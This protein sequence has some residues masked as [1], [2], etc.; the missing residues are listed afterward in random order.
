MN[1]F[2]R[3][4]R[5]EEETVALGEALG[6]LLRPGDALALR[7]ELGAGKTRFV[8]GVATG[9][10]HDPDAV[11]SPTFVLVNEYESRGAA[12]LV[13]VDAYRLRSAADLDAIGWDRL[14]DGSC[15]VAVEWSERIA[16]AL[17]D[18]RLDVSFAH[19][20]EGERRI[21]FSWSDG[22]WDARLSAQ[23]VDGRPRAG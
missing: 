12:P 3:I 1:S 19:E 6:R 2:E 9:M 4:T 18:S 22:A 10:G 17:P 5:S 15:V 14:M 13:H 7:G 21:V 20:G 8:R 16:G 23:F 11:S